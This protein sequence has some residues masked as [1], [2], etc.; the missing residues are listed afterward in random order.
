MEDQS[1]WSDIF[2][3]HFKDKLWSDDVEGPESIREL[4]RHR[5]RMALRKGLSLAVLSHAE[6]CE[7]FEL[8][9]PNVAAGRAIFRAPSFASFLRMSEAFCTV[10]W[11]R[12]WLGVKILT[13]KIGPSLMSTYRASAPGVRSL[14]FPPCSSCA[15]AKFS[16]R[17]FNLVKCLASGGSE[18]RGCLDAFWLEP[19]CG[20]S[21]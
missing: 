4:W 21:G 14:W 17:N 19:T 11:W 20:Y 15:Y 6:F 5:V 9:K 1:R 2:P 10:L 8:V 18:A 13:S 7:A 16:T 3:D 12:G